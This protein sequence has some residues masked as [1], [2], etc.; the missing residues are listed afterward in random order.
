M[1]KN[2]PQPI[3]EEAEKLIE[4]YLKETA[5]FMGGEEVH[6]HLFAKQCAMIACEMLINNG[7]LA[8]Q[9]K[10]DILRGSPPKKHE[11]E[12]WFQVKRH[13]NEK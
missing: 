8:P 9:S 13:V 10:F 6:A 3:K 11:L 1:G 7:N 2:T 5:R 12:Y 4:L